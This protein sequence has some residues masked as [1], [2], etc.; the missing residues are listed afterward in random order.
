MIFD[1]ISF[2]LGFMACY[3]IMV[4]IKWLTPHVSIP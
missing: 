4:L 3:G 2:V 1:A